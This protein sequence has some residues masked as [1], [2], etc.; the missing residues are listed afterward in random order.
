[1]TSVYEI[2]VDCPICKKEEAIKLLVGIESDGDESGTWTYLEHETR[3]QD[4]A[5]DLDAEDHWD[6]VYQVA[7]EIYNDI[8][9]A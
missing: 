5:C 6:E 1:M 7:D 4:C 8:Y 2:D 9:E 3:G